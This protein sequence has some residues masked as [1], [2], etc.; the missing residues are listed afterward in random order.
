M[1][2]VR[3]HIVM[4]PLTNKLSS[5]HGYSRTEFAS[6]AKEYCRRIWQ[7]KKT[8]TCYGWVVIPKKIEIKGLEII[9]ARNQIYDF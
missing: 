7:S 9:S 8:K 3:M 4:L 6:L 2:H 1:N 5:S